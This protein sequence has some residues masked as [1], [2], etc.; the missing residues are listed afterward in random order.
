MLSFLIGLR[1]TLSRKQ[2]HLVAFISRLSI[3]AMVLAVAILITVMSVMNGFDK[4]LRED[5]LSLV[6]HATIT[7]LKQTDNWQALLTKAKSVERVIHAEPFAYMPALLMNQQNIQQSVSFGIDADYLQKNNALYRYL[8][9]SDIQSLASEDRI[10]LGAK[11]AQKLRAEAGDKVK[12]LISRSSKGLPSVNYFTVQTVLKTGTELDQKV[13]LLHRKALAKMRGFNPDSVDGLRLYVD[14]IF[15]A[16]SVA[17][18]VSKQTELFYIKDWS[19]THGNLYQAIQMSRS[20]VLLLVFIIIAVAAFNVVSTLVLAVNDKQADIAILR[21]MGCSSKQL[22][23][24]FVVQGL[25]IGLL[26][27]LGGVILGVLLSLG[28]DDLVKLIE[29]LFN[30]QFLQT[31]VYPIDYLPSDIHLQDVIVVSAVAM[32]LS[33]L[34]TVFPAIRAI[35]LQPAEVL[36]HE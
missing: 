25:V 13:A 17:N 12:F 20:M 14:D 30:H 19:R 6:P 5:I 7:G 23:A 24:I 8:S 36:R 15:A 34:A 26:G 3:A 35:R 10:I 21:T 31:E 2:S 18:E 4:A 28:V 29:Q 9:T 33:T 32:L 1:Y 11:L 22:I 16:N 27:V